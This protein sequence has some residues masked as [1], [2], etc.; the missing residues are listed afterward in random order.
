MIRLSIAAILLAF[1]VLLS[2]PMP[3][4]AWPGTVVRVIDGDSFIIRRHDNGEDIRIRLFG[5]D[6]PEKNQPYGLEAGEFATEAVLK[7][8]VG[9]V[10][11]NKDRY[12]RTVAAII[13]LESGESLEELLLSAGLAW[14]DERF[15]KQCAAW[16]SL[17]EQARTQGQG[18]W[19]DTGCLAPWAWRKKSPQENHNS[20]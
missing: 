3:A 19:A 7:K 1:L 18:M 5:I 11:L 14:V 6:S 9:V 17:Q 13:L 20:N 12:G 16:L 8:A 10:E 4:M 15:C 2:I